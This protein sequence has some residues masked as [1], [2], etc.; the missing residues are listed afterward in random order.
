[1]V[2]ESRPGTG[3]GHDERSRYYRRLYRTLRD[4]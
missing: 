3:N 1:M 2:P 4:I